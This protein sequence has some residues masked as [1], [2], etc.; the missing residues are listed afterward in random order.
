MDKA[1]GKQC[2]SIQDFPDKKKKYLIYSEPRSPTSWVPEIFFLYSLLNMWK[3]RIHFSWKY[4]QLSSFLFKRGP[5]HKHSREQSTYFKREFR[6]RLLPTFT[7]LREKILI[8]IDVRVLN[9]L[10]SFVWANAR[11]IVKFS[12]IHFLST[13]SLW[14]HMHNL[15]RQIQACIYANKYFAYIW[16]RMFPSVRDGV[17]ME[18]ASIARR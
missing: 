16:T 12:A 4:R 18:E 11:I 15:W 8:S 13:W 7:T 3:S 6:K 5:S 14:T 2:L 17:C 1:T 9:E 10:L